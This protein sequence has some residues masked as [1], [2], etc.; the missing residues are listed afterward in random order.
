[1]E[2]AAILSRTLG[3][4]TQDTEWVATQAG[5]SVTHLEVEAGVLRLPAPRRRTLVYLR[6]IAYADAQP[7]ALRDSF[8]SPLPETR[9]KL[10]GMIAA[11]SAAEGVQ[12]QTYATPDELP[13]LLQRDM[14]AL[15]TKDFPPVV[16]TDPMATEQASHDAFALS[17]VE[18]FVPLSHLAGLQEALTTVP[19]AGNDDVPT[20]SN[21]DVT[22]A[23]NGDVTPRCAL[24]HG[25]SGT[26]KSSLVAQLYMT[27]RARSDTLVAIHFVGH[28]A[29]SAHYLSV[30]QVRTR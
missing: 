29:H 5:R 12:L 24:L 17:R 27:L 6:D 19:A 10:D 18:N 7:A 21:D 1:M 30:L 3:A 26:G 16:H 28:T 14:L 4:S 11:L 13:A 25:P 2:A 15:I 9:A 23:G 8:I 20:A 22:K